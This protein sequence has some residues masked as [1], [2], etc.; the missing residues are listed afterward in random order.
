MTSLLS[1]LPVAAARLHGPHI[2]YASLMPFLILG[3]GAMIVLIV[4]IL[5]GRE[6]ARVR[7][8]VVPFVT[9]VALAAS[10]V[11]EI[12]RYQHPA[13]IVAGAL[14]VDQLSFTLDLIFSVA[15]MA[16]VVLSLNSRASSSAGHGE[17]HALLL[18]SIMG[19]AVLV[20][21][22]NLVTLF[23]GFELL[24][25]PLYVLCASE[26][27]REGS[28]ESGLKYLVV[29]SVGSATLLYGLA[30][31]YGATGST[32]FT[33]IASAISGS[34]LAA[35]VM[36]DPMLLTG[37]GLALVGFAFKASVAPFHQWTPD[38]YEGAPT[39]ITAFMAVA[40]KAAALGVILR[41]FDVAAVGV[42]TDW[43]P[44]MATIAAITIIVGN[45]GA[46]SQS[47]VKRMLGYSSVGQAGY[48]LAG[49]V[50]ATKLGA[51]ATVLYLIVYLLMN[52][53]AFAV[54]VATQN[55]RADGDE[56]SG[57]AG[58]GARSP[59]LAWPLTIA[60]LSL[61]GIPG[62]VGFIGKFQLI[63]ALVDGSYTWLA[64]V[65]VIGSMISLGYYLRVVA[66][67][68]MRTET[69]SPGPGFVARIA[70]LG[71]SPTGLA[72][73]AGGSPEADSELAD[74]SDGVGAPVTARRGA[75]FSAPYGEVAFIA[76]VFA[77]ATIVFGVFP[78]PLFHLADHAGL[79]LGSLF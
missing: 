30:L 26:F 52:V 11:V 36:G 13:L 68:W 76:V 29:G 72:P 4:G 22:V 27:R 28:L 51:D 31:V 33:G 47:S 63:H 39:P 25:I 50:V 77:A 5:G 48:M 78:S 74:S 61:A 75:A 73:L 79:A 45:V 41:F 58:L 54:I 60:M 32:Q 15:G 19:M 12:M 64:I 2:D 1:M 21:A 14:Q 34:G 44:A 66:A 37:I 55:E 10:I 57:I 59:W 17:Y 53:A 62:T 69:A 18:F 23:L 49:V 9:L 24:S 16:C 35:G 65:L 3:G 38:V 67:I 6:Q 46:L 42:Q 40:T 7:A 8:R 20:S 70:G 43:A 56:L 71:A